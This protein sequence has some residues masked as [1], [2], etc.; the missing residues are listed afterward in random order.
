MNIF[1]N[2]LY[3]VIAWIR[4]LGV[5]LVVLTDAITILLRS[6]DASAG[7]TIAVSLQP[8]YYSRD[9]NLSC[10]MRLNVPLIISQ[11]SQCFVVLKAATLFT[12]VPCGTLSKFVSMV[13][14]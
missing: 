5:T 9:G 14:V 7:A 11:C 10:P 2:C 13:A 4:A 12:L 8:L 6:Q 1:V 3:M